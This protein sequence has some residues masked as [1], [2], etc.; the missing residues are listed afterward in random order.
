MLEGE[1]A[2]SAPTRELPED[3]TDGMKLFVESLDGIYDV[4]FDAEL[5][6]N[7][8]KNI[9]VELSENPEYIKLI[10]D[11]DVHTM[12]RGMRD[13]MGLA[14]I[15]KVESKRGTGTRK[16]SAKTAQTAESVEL[17]DNMFNADDF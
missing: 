8:T 1:T 9:M 16:T 5:F 13:A 12:I 11:E 7:M 6:G 4:L 15:K 14:R 17:L 3:M 10:A 2:A